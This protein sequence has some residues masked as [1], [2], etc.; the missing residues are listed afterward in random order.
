MGAVG[1]QA[2]EFRVRRATPVAFGK[3]EESPAEQGVVLGP[4][5]A[6][7]VVAEVQDSEEAQVPVAVREPVQAAGE[8]ESVAQERRALGELKVQR[9]A[10]G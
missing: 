4:A 6:E 2:E 8:L 7:R 10:S 1:C 9:Q 3:R 5:V